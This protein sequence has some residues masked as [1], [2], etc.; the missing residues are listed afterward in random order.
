MKTNA[1]WKWEQLQQIA[2]VETLKENLGKRPILV[3]LNPKVDTDFNQVGIAGM[4]PQVHKIHK[5][6]N[7][8]M[9]KMDYQLVT[10]DQQYCNQRPMM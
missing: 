4:L 1:N 5:W 3:I 7:K 10:E 9:Q 6:I 2:S 8:K